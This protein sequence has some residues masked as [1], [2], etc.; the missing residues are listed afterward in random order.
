MQ[1]LCGGTCAPTFP[2]SSARASKPSAI[3]FGFDGS[4]S[5]FM[6]TI[7]G[8][9]QTFCM[10]C[11]A[12]FLLSSARWRLALSRRKHTQQIIQQ[13]GKYNLNCCKTAICSTTIILNLYSVIHFVVYMM[14]SDVADYKTN[15]KMQYKSK[16]HMQLK[17][18]IV[19]FLDYSLHQCCNH[20][21]EGLYTNFQIFSILFF[22]VICWVC[23]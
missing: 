6:F 15:N 11:W 14:S 8:T 20:P 9:S 12:C 4:A 19:P 16:L 5:L 3:Q 13:I 10:I 21:L 17:L 7:V 1:L 23:L 2:A 18:P 22:M